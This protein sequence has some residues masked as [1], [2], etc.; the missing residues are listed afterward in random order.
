MN[1]FIRIFIVIDKLLNVTI[2]NGSPSE[3]MSAACYRMNRDGRFWGFMMPIIDF[4]F[5]WQGYD[6]HCYRAYLKLIDRVY[7]PEEYK[8]K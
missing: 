4:M 1:Y 6:D 7:Y 2:C 8:G 3:T 5:R